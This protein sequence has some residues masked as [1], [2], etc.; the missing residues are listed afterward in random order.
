[1]SSTTTERVITS[2]MALAA[3]SLIGVLALGTVRGDLQTGAVGIGF[4][5]SQALFDTGQ[6]QGLVIATDGGRT[7][8]AVSLPDGGVSAG[9]ELPGRATSIV[10]TPGGVSVWVSFADRREIEVYSTV[11]LTL[12]ATLLPAGGDGLTPEHLTFSEN[13]DTL[14]ITW[15]EDPRISVYR[16]QMRELT[17][18]QEIAP[19]VAAATAGPV[20]RNRRATRL[21]RVEESGGLAAF[22]PQ[23]GQRLESIPAPGDRLQIAAPPVFT[24]DYTAA[25]A[26]TSTRGLARIDIAQKTAHQHMLDL[27]MASDHPP[28]L[29]GDALH[30]LVIGRNRRG[31]HR[32]NLSDTGPPLAAGERSVIPEDQEETSIVTMVAAGTAAALILTTDGRLT[33]LDTRSLEVADTVQ[34][35]YADRPID[36]VLAAAWEINTEG[37]FACF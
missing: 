12:Q 32:L 29:T 7:L 1:M 36:P 6:E 20:I 19:D 37:S 4:A 8:I 30:M 17:L 25:W 21:F 27:E 23:N 33:V 13:G 3:L 5:S 34:I 15:R 9:V 10:P 31:V 14:S 18:L 28:V 26:V 24:A 16:H 2:I 35:Q 22:F 11:D